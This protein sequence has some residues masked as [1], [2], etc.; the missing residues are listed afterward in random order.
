MT[1]RATS[2]RKTKTRT[3]KRKRRKRIR[4][5]AKR[6]RSWRL[7]QEGTIGG[8]GMMIVMKRIDVRGKEEDE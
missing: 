3:R 2:M 6:G 4:K 7:K 5:K 8:R 1:T